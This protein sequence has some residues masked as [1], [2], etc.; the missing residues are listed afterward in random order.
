MHLHPRPYQAD[1]QRLTLEALARYPSTLVVM[2]TGLGKTVVFA[3][4]SHAWTQGRVLV[5]AHREELIRQAADKLAAVTGETPAV[6][7]GQDD[8]SDED[9]FLKAKV[10]VSSVQT[11]CRPKRHQRFNP[12]AF[13]L[14][15]IDEAHHAAAATYKAVVSYF[16][17]NDALRLLGVTATPKRHDQLALGQLFDSVAFDYGIAEA[18]DDGWLV[19]VHQQ[20]VKVEGLDFSKARATAGDL[21]ESDLHAALVQEKHLHA[22]AAPAIDLAG[23]RSA[24]V[25]AVDV[26]HARL[27]A[28]MLG[29]YKGSTASAAYL[30]GKSSPQERADTVQRFRDGKLQFLCNC[31]LFLEGFD[32]PN[33][34]LVV[35]ARPTTSLALYTQVLGRG[36]RPLPGIVD[37]HD[38]PE[39]RRAAIAASAKPHMLALDFAGNAGRHKIIT[40]A[41]VLGGKYGSPVRAYAKKTS[42][43]EG[44]PAA[45]GESLDRAAAEMALEAAQEEWRRRLTARAEFHTEEVSPFDRRQVTGK[46][47]AALPPKEPATESQI[48]YLCRL[49]KSEE[50]ARTLSKKQAGFWIGKLKGVV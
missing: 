20:V 3:R 8:W 14:L 5:L 4:I 49:G 38:S 9:S 29:R 26:E 30:H 34:A 32:A 10:V 35:M 23:D 28:E 19:P 39:Q 1:C 43:D 13:G 33:T 11:M 18:V 46:N 2:A 27:L 25:F 21:N 42:T 16:R 41:D 44:K 37:G 24:L 6:E 7:M 36:T 12:A 31:G 40:A 48:R 45:V 15:I 47:G 17:Q 22:V 50:W